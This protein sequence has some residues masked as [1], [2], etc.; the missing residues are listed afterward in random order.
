MVISILNVL[1]TQYE[2]EAFSIVISLAAR[3]VFW[4]QC[5]GYLTVCGVED[6][7]K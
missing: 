6:S 7:R 4:W 5:H 3:L 1:N 2:F